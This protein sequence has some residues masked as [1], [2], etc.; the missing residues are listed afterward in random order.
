MKQIFLGSFL[1]ALAMFIWGFLFWATPIS[2]GAFQETS[3]YEEIGEALR[4]V[5]PQDGSY[6]VPWY[7]AGDEEM[8]RLHEAG[9]LATI[10]FRSAGAPMG[11]PGVMI[12]GFVHMFI[13]AL[14]LAMLLR[15]ALPALSTYGQRVGLIVLA[16]VVASFWTEISAPIWWYHPWSFAL[17]NMFYSIISFALAG[18]VLARFIGKAETVAAM[19]TATAAG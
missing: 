5:L 14:M 7:G 19:N 6:H 8:M 10:H 18:L 9:P 16:G 3:N 1:A 11:S 12:W 2:S 13:T 4:D 15:M 17:T